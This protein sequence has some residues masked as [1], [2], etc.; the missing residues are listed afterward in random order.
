MEAKILKNYENTTVEPEK[1]VHT[2]NLS[3]WEVE[4][5]RS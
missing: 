4:A 1:M 3:T 2:C 5:G